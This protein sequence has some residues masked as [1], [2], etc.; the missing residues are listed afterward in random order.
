V[1]RRTLPTRATLYP[2]GRK[3]RACCAQSCQPARPRAPRSGFGWSSRP[4]GAPGP[5]PQRRAPTRPPPRS[6]SA[7]TTSA[8]RSA[9]RRSRRSGPSARRKRSSTASAAH[10][11]GRWPVLDVA[12]HFDAAID[13][14]E[15][16]GWTRAGTMTVRIARAEPLAE[17]VYV[18]PEPPRR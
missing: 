11:R 2:V 14:Y 4:I 15:R 17:H 16:D 7:A 1:L 6:A 10:E 12:T 9:R 3:H 13:L 18:G 8:A 5:H